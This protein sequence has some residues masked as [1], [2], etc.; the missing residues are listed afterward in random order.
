MTDG[1]NG[2]SQSIDT[3]SSQTVTSSPA[4]VQSNAPAPIDERTFKQQEV[5]EIV[6]RAKYDAVESFR[7]MQTD[8][9]Q[10]LQQKYG[11]A[12]VAQ[13][14]SQLP[15][16]H[17]RKIAAEEAHKHLDNVRKEAYQKNQDENAQRTVTNFFNKIS[18]GKEK[19]KDFDSMTGD[20]QLARFPNVVQL[21]ADHV[22]NAGDVYY[23][24]GKDRIKM[25]NLEQLAVMSQQDAIVQVRRLSQSIKDNEA[26]SKVRMPNEP[27][28]Q[29]RPSNTGTDNGAMSVT[30]YR[31]KYKV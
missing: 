2:L 25:A 6:K 27:L 28:S 14:P 29:L 20:V 4:P 12:N 11:E 23:E 9:P 16:E 30:D 5:S 18:A 8:Q 22:D 10:Y 24:L 7:K 17:F 3:S 21:M 1:T 31:K 19:Y 26:A 13:Q 15:D